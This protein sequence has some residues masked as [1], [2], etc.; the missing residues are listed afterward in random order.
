MAERPNWRTS[1][2]RSVT[3]SEL[4]AMARWNYVIITRTL[5]E[6]ARSRGLR[7]AEYLDQWEIHF[8]LEGVPEKIRLHD[9][10]LLL[11]SG[12]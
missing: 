7:M 11:S 5:L 8:E 1:L 10:D 4:R 2:V 12:N 9:E 3:E 6:Q